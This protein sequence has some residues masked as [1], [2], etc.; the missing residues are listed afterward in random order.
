MYENV[1]IS[2]SMKKKIIIHVMHYKRLNN[3]VHVHVMRQFA[4][5]ASTT[6]LLI[7]MCPFV[8]ARLLLG[9]PNH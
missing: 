4:C 3:N 2:I 1:C 9:S 6:S 8:I 5:L 7:T